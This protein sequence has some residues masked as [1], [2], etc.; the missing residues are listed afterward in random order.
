MMQ[1]M[2]VMKMTMNGTGRKAARRALALAALACVTLASASPALALGKRRFIE[3]CR[4]GDAR[5]LR[6]EL[7]RDKDFVRSWLDDEGET[8]LMKASEEARSPE[9]IEALLAAGANVND[10]DDDG[11]TALM[12]AMDDYADIQIVRALLAGGADVSLEDEEG[13][14]ALM[15]ALKEHAGPDVILALLDA[16][17][18]VNARDYLGHSVLDYARRSRRLQGTEV[19]RRIEEESRQN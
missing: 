4:S 14:T 10:Q 18:A 15:H 8:P 3:L 17:A 1:M 7:E 2:K 13:R 9:I 6:A 19:L 12:Y 16:G 11:E 5:E